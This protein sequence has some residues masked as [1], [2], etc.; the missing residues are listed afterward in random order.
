M[1]YLERRPPKNT[2]KIYDR[3]EQEEW[4]AYCAHVNSHN[5]VCQTHMLMDKVF[6]SMLYQAF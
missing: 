1:L 6:N 3:I 2:Q 4:A 5:T